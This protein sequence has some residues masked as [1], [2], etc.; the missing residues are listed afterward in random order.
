MCMYIIWIARMLYNNHTLCS[1][2][3]KVS[4]GK[5]QL[6]PVPSQLS[7]VPYMRKF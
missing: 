5:A 2:T 4:T 1:G 6:S 3:V 7:V